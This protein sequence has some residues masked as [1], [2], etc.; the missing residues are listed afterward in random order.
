[1]KAIFKQI[2]MD[3]GKNTINKC[4]Q[5]LSEMN[6][7]VFLAFA[8]Y[9]GKRYLCRHLIKLRSLKICSFIN[10]LYKLNNFLREIPPV[11]PGQE[12]TPFPKM[13]SWMLF[14]IPCLPCGKWRWLNKSSI[15]Q[16]LISKKWP[17]SLKQE[18]KV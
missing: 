15:I 6:K 12:T 11:T 18:W 14:V 16:T 13:R 10:M 17:T 5:K 1:M 4:N 8:L 9:K 7:H 3:I 2:V